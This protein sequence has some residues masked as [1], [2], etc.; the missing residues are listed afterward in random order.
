MGGAS[1]LPEK[2]SQSRL[3]PSVDLFGACHAS[4]VDNTYVNRVVRYN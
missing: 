4:E 3:T 1:V 2:W